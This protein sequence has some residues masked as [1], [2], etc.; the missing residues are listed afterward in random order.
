MS[1]PGPVNPDVLSVRGVS[2]AF[3]A[4]QALRDVSV[5]CRAGE[6]HALVGEN[7]SG[8]STLL[9][10][11][12]GFLHPDEG[13]VE[14]GGHRL[15]RHSPALARR[16][17]LGIAY[18]D[19]SHVLGLSIAENLY[20]AVPAEAR[21]PYARKASWAEEILA[22]F[23]LD[24]DVTASAGSLSL[25][26]RQL[27]EVAKTLLTRPKV[28]L[29]DEPTTALGPDAVEQLHTLV[30]EQA[31]AGVGIVYVSHRLPE[32]LAVAD[33]V[34][35]LR[36]GV[37][38][39]TY[40]AASVSEEDLIALMIGRPL[41]VAFPER[42]APAA[43]AEVLL[44]VSSFRGERFGPI[45]LGVRKG[46]ILGIAGAEGNGQV[47]FLRALAGAERAI[48]S[49][50]CGSEELDRSSP[51]GPL[52]AGVVLLS[53]DRRG[54]ALFPVL[55]VRANATIEALRKLARFG[56]VGRGR[57]RRA[58]DELVRRLRVRMASVEQP[59]S[60]LSGG[61]QQKVS[62]I[63]PFLRGGVQVILADEPT[64]G[65]DVGARFDIY[66]ALHAR[67]QE[68]VSAIVKS[69]DPLEL[70]GLCDRVVVMSRGRIV[71]EIPGDELGERRIVEA[72]VG[73]RNAVAQPA[74]PGEGGSA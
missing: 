30:L 27:L 65:V 3:G 20:L 72:I 74:G 59:V 22:E 31:R 7:G 8:K 51:I 40:E 50:S 21:P 17:G 68:G 64:Q 39:G 18:Q 43:H 15:R 55:S 67:A 62:L 69:S 48:G 12:S 60:S 16:L 38:Q 9:G 52:R 57:E 36:D 29:L 6:I 37:G 66:E 46:E 49:V 13:T 11:A 70:A 1:S 2:K 14:I 63:R 42:R 33:R 28:L 56:I 25:A 35:A 19:Y 58:I 71:E 44:T 24:V 61:N 10:I 4:V 34:T 23:S 26:Q 53:G 45:D 32:V 54:E 41:T 5:D 73:S 47:Q